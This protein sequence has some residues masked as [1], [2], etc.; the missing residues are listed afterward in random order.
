M[1][2]TM[3]EVVVKMSEAWNSR[4]VLVPYRISGNRYI[5]AVTDHGEHWVPLDTSWVHGRQVFEPAEGAWPT[6]NPVTDLWLQAVMDAYKL[7]HVYFLGQGDK[8]ALKRLPR[9]Q[10]IAEGR[11]WHRIGDKHD[12]WL[13]PSQSTLGVVYMVNGRCNCPDVVKWCKHRLGRA[14][15][16]R[17]AE[18]L[19]NNNGAGDEVDTPTPASG[20]AFANC[21]PQSSTDPLNGQA[22][23]IDLIVGYQADDSAVLPHPAAN[24]ELIYFKA[25]GHPGEPPTWAMPELYRWLQEHNYIPHEFKWLGWEQGLRQRRQ[26]YLLEVA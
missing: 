1:K 25:D 7:A 20:G 14:L 11:K 21:S 17:A 8:A 22:R 12:T 19:K 13:M 16:K 23:R 9:A 18:L 26:T 4:A 3:D 10:V 15:A 2:R 24:G 5:Y 6:P